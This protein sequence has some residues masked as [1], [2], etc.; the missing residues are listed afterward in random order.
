MKSLEARTSPVC[1]MPLCIRKWQLLQARKSVKLN[2]QCI[3]QTFQYGSQAFDVSIN[4][5]VCRRC[6]QFRLNFVQSIVRSYNL[7]RCHTPFIQRIK[8]HAW[9]ATICYF[10]IFPFVFSIRLQFKL[11]INWNGRFSW[12]RHTIPGYEPFGNKFCR[13]LWLEFGPDFRDT[14][15]PSIFA[16]FFGCVLF[17]LS[18]SISRFC[19]TIRSELIFTSIT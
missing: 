7:I 11:Y 2:S 3:N 9:H 8:A 13:F 1:W 15:V 6:L 4:I 16:G 19:G 14:L 5:T 17:S 12:L 18:I 10:R